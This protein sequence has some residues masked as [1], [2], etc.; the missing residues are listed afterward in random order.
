MPRPPIGP[1]VQTAVPDEIKEW[2]D[3]ERRRRRVKEGVVTRELIL[4]GFA[5][6]REG[7]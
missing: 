2:I 5:A 4:A 3:R 6:S 1:K 7:A